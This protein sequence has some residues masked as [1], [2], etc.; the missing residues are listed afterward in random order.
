MFDKD[1]AEIYSRY[2]YILHK[3]IEIVNPMTIISAVDV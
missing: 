2:D 1:K 3:L